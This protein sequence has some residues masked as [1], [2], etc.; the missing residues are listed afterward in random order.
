MELQKKTRREIM[1]LGQ[2]L[3]KT[4]IVAWA[5][6]E[7]EEANASN[8]GTLDQSAKIIAEA[9][10]AAWEEAERAKYLSR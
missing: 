7:E 10:A 6:K 1:V 8:N 2:Q 5:S 4:N 3:G 9:R